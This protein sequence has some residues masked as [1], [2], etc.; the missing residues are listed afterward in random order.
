MT[1]DKKL[2]SNIND[3]SL[4]TRISV[5]KKWIQEAIEILEKLK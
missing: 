3:E 1:G 5:H 4:H 2:D